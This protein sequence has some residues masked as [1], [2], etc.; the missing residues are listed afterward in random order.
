VRAQIPDSKLYAQYCTGR[1]TVQEQELDE[2]GA[3][4][5][6]LNPYCFGKVLSGLRL[7]AL[8]RRLDLEA[9]AANPAAAAA[10]A[11]VSNADGA[12]AG[13]DGAGDGAAA[14]SGAIGAGSCDECIALD[15]DPTQ[16]SSFARTLAYLQI[17]PKLF[18]PWSKIAGAM[19]FSSVLK[20]WVG[21]PPTHWRL[22]Y[23]GSRDGF[24]ASVFHSRCNG[25]A[26]TVT[27]IQ[28]AN[29][30]VFGGFADSPWSSSGSY[31]HSS[32]AF[33]FSLSVKGSGDVA[34]AK[35]CPVFQSHGNA[36]NHNPNYGPTFGSGHDLCIANDCSSNTSSVVNIGNVYNA[37][38]SGAHFF[39]GGERN[40]RVAEIEVF[41]R[42]S[43]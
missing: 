18:D 39:T 29:N 16:A 41:A 13:A 11:A 27:I 8:N 36:L 22:L 33:L 40:F 14:A 28:D 34:A 26:N 19:L 6:D 20:R 5:L 42:E 12:S 2:D 9:A 17:D 43:Q 37:S 30:S 3:I 38:G 4:F 10:A 35:Q 25:V 31:L 32:T 21:S 24:G 1:W 23:R 15:I 7:L